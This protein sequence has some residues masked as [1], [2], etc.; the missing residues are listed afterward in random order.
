MFRFGDMIIQLVFLLLIVLF[1]TA[2]FVMIRSVM[3]NMREKNDREQKIE[4]KLDRVITL[5]EKLTM[6][7]KTTGWN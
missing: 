4:A 6:K 2:L 5:L 7:N 3:K 1:F